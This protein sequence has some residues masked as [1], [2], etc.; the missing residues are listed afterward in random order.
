M[1]VRLYTFDSCCVEVSLL[2]SWRL[3]VFQSSGHGTQEPDSNDEEVE[4]YS[5][6]L[7][8]MDVERSG[9]AGLERQAA[10]LRGHLPQW[11]YAPPPP[12]LQ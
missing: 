11:H 2:H 10:C 4:G 6:A 1:D 8:P 12:P 9:T 3:L 5:E 7:C